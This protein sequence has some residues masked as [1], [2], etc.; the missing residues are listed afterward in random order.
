MADAVLFDSLL[1]TGTLS[2]LV[3]PERDAGA[4][5]HS[6]GAVTMLGLV[7]NTCCFDARVK[8]AISGGH[9]RRLST[10]PLRLLENASAPPGP[11][12]GR[13]ADPIQERSVDLQRGRGPK[14]LLTDGGSH[15]G[16]AGGDLRSAPTV[17]RTTTDFRRPICWVTGRLNPLVL[18]RAQRYCRGSPLNWRRV[19][20]VRPFRC[21]R[22][23]WSTCGQRLTQPQ[24][25]QRRVGYRE[26]DWLYGRQGDQH[27]GVLPRRHVMG[28][29]GCVF[30]NAA[31]SIPIPWLRGTSPCVVTGVW[32]RHSVTRPIAASSPSTTP[33]H[34][35]VWD[36]E[37]LISFADH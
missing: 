33:A 37:L 26:L 14:G 17:I 35:V 16:A 9:H 36:Q 34:Q 5:G 24:P 21:R 30:A 20:S 32:R 10:G 4:A 8:A 18:R 31:R 2:G 3:D 6:N 28:T 11:W 22:F 15:D 27:P 23:R 25:H 13:P 29:A 7:A 12:H 1:P 19:R